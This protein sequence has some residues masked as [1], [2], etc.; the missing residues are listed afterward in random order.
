MLKDIIND[1]RKTQGRHPIS[2]DNQQENDNCLFHCKYMALIQEC[3]HAPHHLRQG[4][5]EAVGKASFYRDAR[6]ALSAIIFEEFANS[7]CHRDIMLFNDNLA[8][9]FH[10]EHN[11]VWVT[12]RGW[13]G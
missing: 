2:L 6:E 8:G 11:I 4:K 1:W 7:M 5:S 13:N 9:A 10:A 3:I 12:I